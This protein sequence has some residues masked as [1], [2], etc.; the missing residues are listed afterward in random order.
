MPTEQPTTMTSAFMYPGETLDDFER[1]LLCALR[2]LNQRHSF[3]VRREPA[4]LIV[5]DLVLGTEWTLPL[6]PEL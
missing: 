3:E 1:R 5:V 2:D 4:Q 6:T